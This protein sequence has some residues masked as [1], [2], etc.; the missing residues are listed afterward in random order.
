MNSCTVGI[1]MANLKQLDAACGTT[2]TDYCDSGLICRPISETTDDGN[3]TCQT[4][5]ATTW[6]LRGKMT[7]GKFWD[8][9]S[10]PVACHTYTNTDLTNFDHLDSTCYNKLVDH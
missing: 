6:K 5:A 4:E 2:S 7:E 9:A 1:D 3:Y 8:Y 10:L